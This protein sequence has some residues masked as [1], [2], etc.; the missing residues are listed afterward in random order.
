MRS[1]RDMFNVNVPT[2]RSNPSDL[3][4]MQEHLG[5]EIEVEN[6]PIDGNQDF[7]EYWNVIHDASLRNDGAEF[8]LARPLS[9]ESLV[10][11]I[12]SLEE[13]LQGVTLSHRCSVHCHINFSTNTLADIEK[14]FY[15]YAMFEPSLY[16]VSNKE[17][18]FNIYCPGLSHAT[19]QLQEAAMLFRNEHMFTRQINNWNKYTGINLLPLRSLGTIEIRT[20]AGTRDTDDLLLWV[21]ILLSLKAAAMRMSLDEIKQLT[22]PHQ[23]V[24]TVFDEDLRDV[25]LCNNLFT[26]WDNAR[27]NIFHLQLFDKM[28]DAAVPKEKAER[29]SNNL[30]RNFIYTELE[31]M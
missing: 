16:T 3:F 30:H 27:R 1:V 26:Y 23:A 12:R 22:T 6:Y 9:G 8:V 15:L 29:D 25:I 5:I 13:E 17:R 11:A 19:A 10:A 7:N 2:T 31:R 20:K 28:L 21:R 18:Y 4:A 14:F 24:T